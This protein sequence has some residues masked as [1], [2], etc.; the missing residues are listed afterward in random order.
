[1]SRANWLE[2]TNKIQQQVMINKSRNLSLFQRAKFMNYYALSE[3]W[4]VGQILPIPK[5][6]AK[7]LSS[8]CGWLLWYQ[9]PM[10]V[11]RTTVILP[12]SMG[13]LNIQ[14]PW[15]EA[16]ALLMRRTMVDSQNGLVE[17]FGHIDVV[18]PPHQFPHLRRFI[19]EAAYIDRDII[20]NPDVN[21]RSI[22]ERMVG[23]NRTKS[24]VERKSTIQK[25]WELIFRNINDPILSHRQKSNIYLLIHDAFP[26]NI[27]L[28]KIGKSLT[29]LCA[30]R[31]ANVET[32]KHKFICNHQARAI[33]AYLLGVLE[34]FTKSKC[35]LDELLDFNFTFGNK[36]KD[37][38]VIQCV[39]SSIVHVI[40][41]PFIANIA[42]YNKCCSTVLEF[43][44]SMMQ[45][46][47]DFSVPV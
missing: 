11:A 2:V 31:N 4:F 19:S 5:L 13:G 46:S 26:F 45:T 28:F 1:M 34:K 25:N 44:L 37:K 18:N 15:Y 32:L 47:I 36:T 7:R 43:F 27:N 24:S 38:F 17:H 22:Y 21:T 12:N 41:T 9:M 6:V 14:D 42:D 20:L 40:E 35:N 10:R 3:A 39:A 16:N 33:T 29:D 23:Q 30:I 8:I